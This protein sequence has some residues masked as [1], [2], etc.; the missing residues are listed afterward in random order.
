[1]C[2]TTLSKEQLRS[3]SLTH[4]TG[5]VISALE[6][7]KIKTSPSININA[8]RSSKSWQVSPSLTDIFLKKWSTSTSY[9]MHHL[10]GLFPKPVPSLESF[11]NCPGKPSLLY[12][13]QRAERPLECPRMWEGTCNVFP[14]EEL[15]E[16]AQLKWKYLA[17][18]IFGAHK[19][20]WPTYICVPQ[21]MS[22]LSLISKNIQIRCPNVGV[23]CY[24]NGL[25]VFQIPT[26]G[27]ERWNGAFGE[28]CFPRAK[29]GAA[30]TWTSQKI[31]DTHG[32]AIEQRIHYHPTPAS[33][34]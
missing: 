23:Y 21:S 5:P 33:Q 15:K 14:L 13:H 17:V 7:I 28:L 20:N 29:V 22:T 27:R 26:Q 12:P 32:L 25:E 19:N 9:P 16:Y 10:V 8:P 30:G 18:R 1:M 2:S 6:K 11:N 4:F 3:L 34:M 24:L 31:L